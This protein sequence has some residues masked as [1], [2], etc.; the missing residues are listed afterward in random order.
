M[1]DSR[2]E[3]SEGNS[4]AMDS[5]DADRKDIDLRLQANRDQYQAHIAEAASDDAQ[6]IVAG[7]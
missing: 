1:Q 2:S 7:T 5:S 3:Q 4:E 6:T